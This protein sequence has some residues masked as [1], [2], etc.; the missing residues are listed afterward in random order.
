MQ[1]IAIRLGVYVLLCYIT[2]A[3]FGGLFSWF[4]NP[5]LAAAGSVLVVGLFANWLSLRIFEQLPVAG[6]GLQAG[7]ASAE[8]LALG[9]AGGIVSASLVLGPPLVVGAAHLTRA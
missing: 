8:N 3:I 9:L 5:I 7:R 1:R 6:I 4:E 2:L